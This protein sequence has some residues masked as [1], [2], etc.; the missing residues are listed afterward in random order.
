MGDKGT[1]KE[2]A[3]SLHACG[4]SQTDTN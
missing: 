1:E 3:A 4:I 2:K